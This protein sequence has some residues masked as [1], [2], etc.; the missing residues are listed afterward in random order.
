LFHGTITI[1]EIIFLE[2]RFGITTNF[3]QNQ[4]QHSNDFNYFWNENQRFFK[5]VKNHPTLV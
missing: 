2:T 4:N 5:K 1:F 3:F